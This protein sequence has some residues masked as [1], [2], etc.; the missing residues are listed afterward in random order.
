MSPERMQRIYGANTDFTEF[1]SEEDESLLQP[2][3]EEEV[4][5]V[6]GDMK[7]CT[8]E[9]LAIMDKQ[10]KKWH[11]MYPLGEPRAKRVDGAQFFIHAD[12]LVQIFK[13]SLRTA[14][15]LLQVTRIKLGKDKNSFVSVKE[16]CCINKADEEAMEKALKALG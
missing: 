11:K 3:S 14:Q 15:K 10:A 8:P 2:T 7:Y 4:W 1:T 13:I 5:A 6:I 16:F 9:T 12:D